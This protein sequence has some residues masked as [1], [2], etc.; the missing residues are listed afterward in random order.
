MPRATRQAFDNMVGTDDE[1]MVAGSETSL[2]AMC[3]TLVDEGRQG[4]SSALT[5]TVGRTER[6][7]CPSVSVPSGD[8]E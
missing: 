6:P 5:S 2:R 3:W 1:I 8:D 4:R 7:A